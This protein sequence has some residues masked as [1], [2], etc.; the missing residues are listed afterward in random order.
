MADMDIGYFG[1]AR[2]EKGARLLSIVLRNV[3]RCACSG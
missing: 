1:D 2:L 3:S